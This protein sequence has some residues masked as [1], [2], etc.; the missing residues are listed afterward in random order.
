[1]G[2]VV[3]SLLKSAKGFSSIYTIVPITARSEDQKSM[4]TLEGGGL[5]IS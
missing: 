1:M 3:F 5:R 4:L 2:F